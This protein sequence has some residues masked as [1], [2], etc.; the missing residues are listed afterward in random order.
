M[1]KWEGE[2]LYLE[3]PAVVAPASTPLWPASKFWKVKVS[4]RASRAVGCCASS[5][6]SSVLVGKDRWEWLYCSFSPYSYWCLYMLIRPWMYHHTQDEATGMRTM[7]HIWPLPL[8]MLRSVLWNEQSLSLRI[9]NPLQYKVAKCSHGPYCVYHIPH[10][11]NLCQLWVIPLRVFS[12]LFI[13]SISQF[14]V[15]LNFDSTSKVK[16]CQVWSF[17]AFSKLLCGWVV[18]WVVLFSFFFHWPH[19]ASLQC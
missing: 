19:D 3:L 12:D 14:F 17:L 13:H 4:V 2:D 16:L 8:S 11:N 7:I 15:S 10:F 5:W 18:F 9:S 6:S 1:F